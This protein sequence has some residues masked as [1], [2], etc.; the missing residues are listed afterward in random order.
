VDAVA[1]GFTHVAF[2]DLFLEDVR[3]YRED[4]LAGSGLEP[5]FPL[6]ERNTSELAEEML[7]GGLEA[8]I[9]CVDRRVLPA[10]FAGRRFDRAFLSELPA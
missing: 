8:R 1:Q 4:R 3:R 5:M 6:W 10:E 7:A 2:G 9:T